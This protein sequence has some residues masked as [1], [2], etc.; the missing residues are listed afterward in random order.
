MSLGSIIAFK[1]QAISLD[2][3]TEP[4]SKYSAAKDPEFYWGP[5]LYSGPHQ[6]INFPLKKHNYTL[7]LEGRF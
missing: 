4:P 5:K 1:Q 6:K 3:A 2:I 7:P